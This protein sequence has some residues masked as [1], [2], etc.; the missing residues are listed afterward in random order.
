MTRQEI[1][2]LACE[3]YPGDEHQ[4]DEARIFALLVD[5]AVAYCATL[6]PSNPAATADI[7]VTALG[8][9][10]DDLRDRGTFEPSQGR[11]A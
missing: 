5:V 9:C 10:L 3:R 6:S 7:T 1:T 11:T 4:C 8:E 2:A